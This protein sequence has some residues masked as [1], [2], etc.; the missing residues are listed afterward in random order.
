MT[1]PHGTE[2]DSTSANETLCLTERDAIQEYGYLAMRDGTR[3]AYVVWRVKDDR[4]YPT[5][6]NYSTYGQ[7]GTPF[8][9]VRRFL[10]AGYAYVGANVRG[11]GA[12]GGA[13]SYYNP[14]EGDDGAEIVEWA[15]AQP[16]ST[17]DVGMIGSSYG[18]H[19]QIS[20]AARQPPH[21]RAI[22]PI[23]TEGNEY[24]DEG[25]TGGMFNAGLL[26]HWTFTMQPQLANIGIAARIRSGDV[27]C[28]A[29]TGTQ[30]PT[31]A[32]EEVL[33][34]PL[35]DEW[36]HARALDR[37][38]ANVT[39]PTLLI[40]AWQDEWIRPNGALSLFRSL[41]SKNKR[42]VLQNGA[43]RLARYRLN[44]QEQMRWLDRWV[45]GEANQVETEPPVQVLWEATESEDG[46]NVTPNWVTRYPAWPAPNLEWLTLYLTA[47]GELKRERVDPNDDH[48][49]R[50]YIYPLGSELVGSNE[51]FSQP[52]NPLGTLSY[53]TE[54]MAS[55]TVL[56]GSPQ[57]TIYVSS[58]QTDTDFMF[59]LK[60]VDP[61]GNTL[62]L[63][64]SV[65]R[66]SLRHVDKVSSKADEIVQSFSIVET[67]VQG[68]IYKV[69]L[70]LSALGHVVR[71]GH[72]LELSILAP[73]ALPNP[74]WAF[75][76]RS[77]VSMNS[78]FHSQRYPS[79]LKLPVIPGER[80]L[81]PARALGVLKNQPYRL[82]EPT[83]KI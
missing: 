45:K 35:Y 13:Y 10:E 82:A 52:P 55:D 77:P 6:L 60:D 24:R 4:R 39:V 76:A 63:Q 41:R 58:D 3:L 71:E 15:A 53:R 12:S 49:K 20:V 50:S 7:A 5:I 8:S 34:H 56:L 26:A 79:E 51:Q 2:R 19:T 78:I 40:H 31:Q 80:A 23:S 65:L 30:P 74:I 66:A 37:I 44:Q 62:F 59:T 38:V 28:A 73:S 21:L 36:W 72:Q 27:E 48:G 33:A 22:V 17:G 68:E 70:S 46:E 61:A 64:R 69:T 54:Q 14:I 43:H 29:G 83:L 57:L 47:A 67:L 1:S 81:K 9:D 75:A 16:W 25:M 18:G 42:L 11:T 32:Y